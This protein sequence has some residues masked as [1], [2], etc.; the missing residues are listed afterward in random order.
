MSSFIKTFTPANVST[1]GFAAS[2]TGATFTLTSTSSGDSLAHKVTVLNNT[3]TDHSGKTLALVGTDYMGNAQTET[4]TAPAGS[5]TVT[6]ANYYLTLTSMTP[7]ATIGADTFSIGWNNTFY[8][9]PVPLNHKG[10][11]ASVDITISGTINIDFESS[12]SDLQNSTAAGDWLV[13]TSTNAGVTASKW[14]TFAAVPRFN[15][16]KANSYSN[17]AIVRLGYAQTNTR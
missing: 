17:G 3:A 1:T 11:V 15:R 9:F 16:V 10:G 8:G 2:V 12:N 13:D 14:I 7:S 4:L 5:A 6:S